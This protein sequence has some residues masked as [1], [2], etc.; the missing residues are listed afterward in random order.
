MKTYKDNDKFNKDEKVICKCRVLVNLSKA[1][2]PLLS[3]PASIN[4]AYCKIN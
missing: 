1:Q 2:F 4:P 3:P